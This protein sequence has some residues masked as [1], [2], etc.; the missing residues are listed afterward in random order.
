MQPAESIVVYATSAGTTAADGTGRNGLF[1]THLLNNLKTPG[2]EIAEVFKRTGAD[3]SRVS[4]REQIP[5]IYSQF[6]GTAY[7]S[8]TTPEIPDGMVKIQGGTFMM[9]S[10]AS[11]ANRED[12]EVQHRV[13]VS[14]FYMGK[15]EVS[16]GEFRR[17]VNAT[18]YKTTAETSGGGRVWTGSAWETKADAN[19]KNPYFSQQDNHPV[20]LV[21]WNDVVRY[22]NWRS[23]QEGLTP[24]YTIN[25]DNVSRNPGGRGYRLPTEAEWEYACRAG[26]TTPFSTGSNITTNQANYDG[27][28]PYNKN[29]KGVYREKTTA[30]GS[31]APNSWGLYDMHGNV[32][33]WCWDC[34]GDYSS[35]AQTDPLGASSG[36]DRVLRGGSWS[37]DGQSL[38][39]ALRF[40]NTPSFRIDYIGFRVL[41]PS[42]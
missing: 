17:F 29:A 5:A 16:V 30:V 10:P 7:L 9:G 31:F 35:G 37:Y 4:N 27:N 38:R 22:C 6:F 23:E 13:T 24:A 15:Y 26:S 40:Y 21:S 28:Y 25:G 39:S 11:E 14:S 2:L 33:E 34:Y 32:W 3:V 41:R 12:D 36:S 20:V 19:W 8:G 1:T 18:G 42:V